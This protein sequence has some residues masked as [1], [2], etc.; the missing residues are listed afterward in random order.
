MDLK[1]DNKKKLLIFFGLFIVFYAAFMIFSMIVKSRGAEYPIGDFRFFRHDVFKDFTSINQAI[2]DLDPYRT[3]LSNYPPII[4]MVAYIFSL[5]ADYS[6]Y[7]IFT[8]RFAINDPNVIKS[9][10]VFFALC[11]VG[12]IVVVLLHAYLQN[13]GEEGKPLKERIK[14]YLLA[15]GIGLA[16]MVSA[17]CIFLVDR[18]N[19]LA[20]AI[21]LFMLWAVFEEEKPDS[22]LGAIFVA[23]CAAIKVYPI[24][25]LLLYV[26]EKKFKKLT[27]ALVT[28]AVVTLVPIFFLKGGYIENV[29]E[30]LLGVLGFGGG[31][32][33]YSIYYSVGVTSLVGFLG[34]LFGFMPNARIIKA[35]WLFSGVIL[36]FLGMPFLKDEKTTWK[37]LLV[38]TAIMVWVTPNSYLYNTAYMFAPIFI[39]LMNRSKME[40]KDYVYVVLS[41][42]LLVPKAYMYLQDPPGTGVEVPLEYSSVN[43][44]VLLDSLLYIGIIGFYFAERLLALGREDKKL[45]NGK[46]LSSFTLSRKQSL[47]LTAVIGASIAVLL[48]TMIWFVRDTVLACHDSIYDFVDA[49]LN[50][51]T[52]GY[53]RAFEYGLARGRVGFIFPLVVMF[54]YLVNA[55]GNFIAIWLMQYLP[56]FANIGLISYVIGKKVSKIHG[57][58]FAVMFLSFLQID[59]W[60]SLITTYPLDFMYGLFIMVLGLYL[61]NEYLEKKVDGKK[62]NIIRLIGSVILYYESMQVYESFIVSSLLYA[63]ITVVYVRRSGLKLFSGEGIKKFVLTILPHFITAVIY[64]GIIVYLR[65][66][67]VVETP[68]SSMAMTSFR[69]FIL[70]YIVFTVGMFPLMS[71][72]RIVSLKELFTGGDIR[73]IITSLMCAVAFAATGFG[74][75]VF[76]RKLDSKGRKSAL[77]KMLVFCLMG[78]FFALTFAIPHAM[79]PSYQ[80]WVNVGHVGGY[81]PTTICYF[82][83]TVALVAIFA[84]VTY[85]ASYRTKRF[86]AIFLAAVM[87]CAYIG[88]YI[89]YGINTS[90]RFT[91]YVTGTE[92]SLKAQNFFALI[93]DDYVRENKPA[94]IYSPNLIGVHFQIETDET[95]AEKLMGYDME[96]INTDEDLLNYTTQ[97]DDIWCYRYDLDAKV[98][99]ITTGTDYTARETAWTTDEPVYFF[100]SYSGDL[101]ISYLSKGGV[102]EY[103]ELSLKEGELVDLGDNVLVSSIDVERP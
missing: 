15:A 100:T 79:I 47:I 29:K 96:I 75:M 46:P 4:L 3:K 27:W 97:T 90:Y 5:F 80:E 11:T 95:L 33:L 6:G 53:K 39:M 50:G 83:W 67:P 12:F 89:T 25:I 16:L 31:S 99:V 56:I 81:V 68:V 74:L 32:G 55:K 17:P 93:E 58:L 40:K 52:I 19:Y 38:I 66:H 57:A 18:G 63:V 51:V 60:H 10:W 28:G 20:V 64:L 88:C 84:L 36:T 13:K 49:R 41:A 70:P 92:Q 45:L 2:S 69:S 87:L 102:R 34:R 101:K 30:F 72:R 43:I 62:L 91:D 71:I 44:A 21:V 9:L 22:V 86:R 35:V 65:S 98:G 8:M 1:N 14:R 23:L 7:D 77:T 73:A 24:Y 82:G 42:L 61:Y 76:Y 48:S 26:F 103:K 94:V 37:K 78:L 85:Y 54:R 59:I